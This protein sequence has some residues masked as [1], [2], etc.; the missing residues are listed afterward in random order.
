MRVLYINTSTGWGGMEMHPLVVGEEL[1]RRGTSLFFA[2][3]KGAP[4]TRQRESWRFTP[5]CLPF[6]W[7]VDPGSLPVLRRM[8]DAFRID[9]VHIHAS[10]DAW[11]A[12]LVA[13]VFRRRRV[14][15]LSRHLA[16]P[17]GIRK[18]DP[19]HRL[20]AR[21]VDAV[22][23]VSGYIRE[24]ILQT[25]DLRE[26]KVRVIP[27]GLG[28]E[29]LGDAEQARLVRRQLRVPEGGHLVGM[30]AQLT[31]DKRPELFLQ[32][33]VRVL[34]QVPGC[35][36]VLAGGSVEPAYEREIRSLVIRLRLEEHVV[37]A[38]FRS[39]VPA[40]MRALDVFVHPARAEAFGLVL[41]E[42]MANGRAVV[43]SASGAV[44][45]IIREEENGLLF[46]PG[47]PDALAMAIVR[48]LRSRDTR[49]RMG[50]RGAEMFR[51]AYSLEREA[52]AT[53]A[54]YRGLL[55]AD[56]LPRPGSARV[57]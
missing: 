57:G 41:I 29:V 22:I 20:L 18:S 37:L 39:D 32:A 12:L 34:Q 31:P 5:I 10:R 19:L 47:D 6:R 50:R 48:L 42:A 11:R 51:E 24:N 15:V 26:D 36:F 43:G 9:L 27:Y 35:R 45:E 25:Y 17:S 7:Y 52:E 46:R 49:E 16:S 14:V 13:G 55:D 8:A 56:R 40:L 1:A 30:V 2:M 54:L 38:G 28:K 23:A 44:P 3:R 53:E 33:A 4:M 21:R